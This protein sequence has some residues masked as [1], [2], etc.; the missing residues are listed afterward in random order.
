MKFL[1]LTASLIFFVILGFGQRKIKKLDVVEKGFNVK[2]NFVPINDSFT[3]N[4]AEFKITPVSGDELNT[5]FLEE[6]SINGKFKYSYY[7][8]SR[9]S[10][11]LKKNRKIQVKSDFDFL[12]LGLEWLIE[13]DKISEL[14][15]EELTKQLNLYYDKEADENLY[16]ADGIILSNPYYVKNKYLSVFKIEITNSSNSFITFDKKIFLQSGNSIYTPLSKDFLINELQRSNMMNFDKS[17]MLEKYNFHDTLL[18]VPHSEFVKYFAV[19]PIKYFNNKLELIIP[20]IN[21][22]LSWS[23]TK[24]EKII[25]EKYTYF[26]FNIDWSHDGSVLNYADVFSILTTSY[27]AI[28]LGNNEMYIGEDNLNE[29]I[30]ILTLSLWGNTLYFGRNSDLKGIDYIDYGKSRRNSIPIILEKI[31]ELKRK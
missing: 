2:I 27:E 23:I 31:S 12:C 24:D 1:L 11:F 25:D 16:L 22:K 7:N 13:N 21:E 17:L 4:K 8:N 5:L 14:E 28:F 30:E 9:S 15:Y 6:S 20:G 29:K 19:T 3:Y 10:Y 26:E 18:I